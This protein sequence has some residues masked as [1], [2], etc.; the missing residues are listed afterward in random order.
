MEKVGDGEPG[1]LRVTATMQNDGSEVVGEYNTVGCVVAQWL[2]CRTVN[3][4]TAVSKL[5]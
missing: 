4:E 3:Q 2:E 1:T 5:G